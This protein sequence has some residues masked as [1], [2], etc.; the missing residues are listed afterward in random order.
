MNASIRVALAGVFAAGLGACA[1]AP[2]E[3]AEGK[4]APTDERCLRETGSKIKNR[5]GCVDG[6]VITSEELEATGAAT[7]GEALTKLPAR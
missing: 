1:S 5:K 2:A 3:V 6:R 7:V 4:A